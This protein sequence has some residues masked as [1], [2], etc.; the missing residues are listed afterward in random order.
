[1][2]DR[3]NPPEV[4]E[5]L[6]RTV[7]I[8]PV[9][10]Q[11]DGPDHAAHRLLWRR[12][13]RGA[14]VSALKPRM[15][16]IAEE[17]VDAF[18]GDGHA[19]L[20]GQFARPHILLSMCAM[21]GI[22]EGDHE[23]VTAGD[24]SFL[25][26]LV[27]TFDVA[28]KKQAAEQHVDYDRYLLGLLEQRRKHPADDM[29]TELAALIDDPDESF[30]EADVLMLIRG[31]FAAGTHTPADAISSTVLNTLRDR[32][33]WERMAADPSVIPGMIE[34]TLRRDAPHRGLMRLTTRDIEL[35]GVRLPAG[36]VI[37]PMLGSANRDGDHFDEP[38]T[39]RPARDGVRSHVAFGHGPHDCV[40]AHL[41]RTHARIALNVLTS[42]LPGLRLAADFT[43]AH[44]QDWFF[45]G[46]DRLDV[47]FPAD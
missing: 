15:E 31:I 8:A 45:W 14:R 44:Y 30:T 12:L 41:A 10:V 47:T 24:R 5:I 34:E 18:A 19:D 29:L 3:D 36:S 11:Y 4:L 22:P 33:R 23:R 21:V 9:I 39:F 35:H 42:R 17:L 43:P 38:D 13:F 26:L 46:L 7:P 40:G 37:F 1:M 28:T 16:Q 20:V 2:L 25:T 32:E 6:S 27:P